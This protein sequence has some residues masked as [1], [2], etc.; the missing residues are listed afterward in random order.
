MKRIPLSGGK[1]W[2]LVDNADYKCL[3]KFI[4]SAQRSNKQ[5]YA[6][7]KIRVPG[8]K[9]QKAIYMHV[10]IFG[11]PCDHKNRNS[12][13][14]RH[15]NLRKATHL[16]QVYNRGIMRN[17]LAGFKGVFYR[18]DRKKWAA[19]HWKNGKVVYLGF[20]K[21]AYDAARA[22][23]IAVIKLAGEFACLNFPPSTG[24]DGKIRY[25]RYNRWKE[26][27]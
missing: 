12:L 10:F 17:N 23:D 15:K 21:N 9:W 7:R 24:A 3:S 2:A 27:A 16:Q 19:R 5:F 18:K 13:D 11:G 1:Y 22:Y 26:N 6:T 25:P 8:Q 20:Y 4:W 14:N